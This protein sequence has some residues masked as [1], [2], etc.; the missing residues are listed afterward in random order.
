[1]MTEQQQARMDKLTTFM[2]SKGVPEIQAGGLARYCLL[3]ILPGQ[4]LT[5]V[6]CNN[7]DGVVRF[8]DEQALAGLKQTYRFIY[9]HLPG[10]C[11]GSAEAVL[12][13]PGV[14]AKEGFE[15]I[16]DAVRF[17]E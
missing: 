1:M 6:L 11:S 2:V 12:D 16:Y 13:W 17:N 4:Y 10:G 15:A 7:L 5:A 3:G 8:G 9:S 14:V